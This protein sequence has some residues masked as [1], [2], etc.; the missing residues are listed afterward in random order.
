MEYLNRIRKIALVRN[1]LYQDKFQHKNV[2]IYSFTNSME[3]IKYNLR[4]I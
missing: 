4:F 3:F 2:L 1:N